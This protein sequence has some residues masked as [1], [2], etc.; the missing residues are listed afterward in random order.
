ML[1]I[2]DTWPVEG[3]NERREIVSWGV[4]VADEI[5]DKQ[6]LSG[7]NGILIEVAVRSR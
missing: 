6:V 5:D 2:S 7:L 1:I 3:A 4:Q